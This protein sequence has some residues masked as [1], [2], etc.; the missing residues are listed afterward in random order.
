VTTVKYT[1][2][3]LTPVIGNLVG[4]LALFATSQQ[5]VESTCVEPSVPTC[6]V[7]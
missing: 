3:A 7:P 2:S 6:P 1:F 4:P 5:S